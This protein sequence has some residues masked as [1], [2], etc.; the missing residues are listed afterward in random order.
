M[1]MRFFELL[2][3]LNY[4]PQNSLCWK[5]SIRTELSQ[6]ASLDRLAD[7]VALDGLFFEVV[8]EPQNVG[9]L[10]EALRFEPDAGRLTFRKNGFVTPRITPSLLSSS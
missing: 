7:E 2:F 3:K 1:I 8:V 10:L 5:I 4:Q 6:C 9:Y